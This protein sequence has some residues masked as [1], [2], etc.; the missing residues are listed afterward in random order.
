[1][2]GVFWCLLNNDYY[3]DIITPDIAVL[4]YIY[5][6]NVNASFKLISTLIKELVKIGVNS[7]IIQVQT[8]NK[9]RFFH[10]A[11]SD[12]NIIKTS[13]VEYKGKMYEDQILKIENLSKV[14]NISFRELIKKAHNYN[15]EEKTNK[16]N[17]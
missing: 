6:K 4:D 3:A 5:S 15:S 12:K 16:K 7:A 8:F 1:M 9:Q 13:P 2:C 14:S 10:Y 17:I 11:L